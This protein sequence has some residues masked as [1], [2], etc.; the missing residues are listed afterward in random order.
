MMR[1]VR[2]TSGRRERGS[3]A[4]E[5]AIIL[6]VFLVLVLGLMDTGRLIWTQT[7]LDRAVEA[8]ARCAS[9]DTAQCGTAAQVQSYAVGQA[10]GLTIESSAFTVITKACG[11]SVAVEYPFQLV[12]PWIADDALTLIASACYPV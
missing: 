10:Y 5:Y 6:P 7:T 11:I 2:K 3:V 9:I 8:A 1:G 4:I 12:I